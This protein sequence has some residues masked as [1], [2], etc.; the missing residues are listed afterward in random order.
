MNLLA[1]DFD[2]TLWFEDHMKDKD[3]QAIHSFRSNGNLFGL[4]SGR[5][6]GGILRP[7]Q[8]YDIDYDFYIMLSGA[9]IYNKDKEIIFEKKIPI[10][11]VKKIY[12]F[13]HEQT[14]TIV[15]ND[16][17]YQL[18]ANEKYPGTHVQSIDEIKAKDINAFSFHFQRDEIEKA[19]EATK[20]INEKFGDYVEAFQNQ[21]NIDLTAKGCSKG[22]GI[23]FIQDYFHLT[24]SQ[25]SV[26]GDSWNDLPMLNQ[27]ENSYTFTYAPK[28]VQCHA[29]Y[30]VSDLYKCIENIK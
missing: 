4:C 26:I 17:M 6:L 2:G 23:A 14:M 19:A 11:I 10:D 21:F 12:F 18:N 15:N 25:I 5:S 1:S 9:L 30:I 24:Q 20:A 27:V 28:D 3:I 7:S 29:K 13:L 16:C 22:N 8:N